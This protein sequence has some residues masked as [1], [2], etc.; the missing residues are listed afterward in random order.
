[1]AGRPSSVS[2]TGASALRLEVL[3]DLQSILDDREVRDRLD[4]GPIAETKG[5]EHWVLHLLLRAQESTNA[6]FDVLVQTVYSNLT[7]RLTAIDDRLQRVEAVGQGL[8]DEVKTR[9]EGI[10][11]SL[12]ERVGREIQTGVGQVAQRVSQDLG[13]NLDTKWKPIGDSV[14]TFAQ[15]SGQLTKDLSDT[16][17]VATQNRLL[18]NENARRIID[19]GRDIVSLEES[20]KLALAKTLEEGLQPLEQRVAALEARLANGELPASSSN[21]S[22][23]T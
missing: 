7:S 21:G 6:H 3:K 12:A 5:R 11:G 15:R 23:H 1:M 4:R 8:G 17:R 10:E 20:L 22:T 19:L 14:E 13:A 2:G 9:L 18:L 16:F